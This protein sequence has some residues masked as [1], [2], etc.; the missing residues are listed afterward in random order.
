MER[1]YDEADGQKSTCVD[2][3]GVA[4]RKG[5]EPKR[6]LT[7]IQPEVS[8]LGVCR[9]IFIGLGERVSFGDR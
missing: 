6:V 5:E 4:C 8:R 3:V 7:T 2:G 9:E 1:L